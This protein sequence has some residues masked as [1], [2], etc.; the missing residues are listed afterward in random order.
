MSTFAVKLA[1]VAR[2]LCGGLTKGGKSGSVSLAGCFATLAIPTGLIGVSYLFIAREC[3]R[4]KN[5]EVIFAY[6]KFGLDKGLK[7]EKQDKPEPNQEEKIMEDEI[8]IDTAGAN[9][10]PSSTDKERP[11]CCIPEAAPEAEKH[12]FAHESIL[13]GIKPD[14]QFEEN[15]DKD[16]QVTTD[17]MTR[18]T[19]FK[20]KRNKQVNYTV[21]S[22]NGVPVQQDFYYGGDTNKPAIMLNLK[23]GT[24]KHIKYIELFFAKARPEN[25]SD[26]DYKDYKDRR[27]EPT[28]FLSDAAG[29]F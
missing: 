22:V 24:R 1:A 2:K 15:S 17:E 16:T 13:D 19:Y 11:L 12:L 18:E 27:I 25:R 20:D 7:V 3:G 10:M 5:N 6:N 26:K 21:D 8:S 4:K 29:G 23:D 14:L 9:N 28:S